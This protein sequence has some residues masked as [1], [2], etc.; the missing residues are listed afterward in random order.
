M[1][2]FKRYKIQPEGRN[3]YGH[4]YSTENVKS[5]LTY[6]MYGGNVSTEEIPTGN[7]DT[8]TPQQPTTYIL[9]FLSTQGVFSSA[10]IA[11]SQKTMDTRLVSYANNTPIPSYIGNFADS[12]DTHYGITGYASSGMSFNILNSGTSATTLQIIVDSGI[13]VSSGTLSIPCYVPK[14]GEEG[15][16]SWGDWKVL[17]D[18]GCL[19]YQELQYDWNMAGEGASVFYLDLTNETGGVNCDEEGHILPGAVL[20]DSWARLYYGEELLSGATYSIYVAP[21]YEANGVNFNTNTGY[22][23]FS[24][25]LSFNGTTLVIEV[26]GTYLGTSRTKKFTLTKNIP[27]Q[28]GQ[29]GSP[30][31]TKWIETSVDEIAFDPNTSAFTPSNVSATVM[32]QVGSGTPYE[33]TSA[34]T[35]YYRF[36]GDAGWNSGTS[37]TVN[38]GF[39]LKDYIEFGLVTPDFTMYEHETVHILKNG[40]NGESVSGSTGPA[41]PAVRGPVDWYSGITVNRRFCNGRGPNAG[42]DKFIDILLKDGTY[43]Q[44]NI[45]YDATPSDSWDSVSGNWTASDAAYDFVATELLLAENAKIKFLSNNALYLMSGDTVTGGAQG[46]SGNTVAFWAGSASGNTAPFSVNHDGHLTARNADIKGNI[47]A[48]TGYF[49]GSITANTGTFA[50][51]VRVPYY[52]IS[53]LGTEI[54]TYGT[55]YYAGEHAYLSLNLSS[56][57]INSKTFTVRKYR[58]G[59]YTTETQLGPGL[60]LPT[61]NSSLN[62]FTYRILVSPYLLSTRF[63]TVGSAD[64]VLLIGVLGSNA[65]ERISIYDYSHS[66]LAPSKINIIGFYGGYIEITC[67]LDEWNNYRWV[68]TTCTGPVSYFTEMYDTSSV[69]RYECYNGSVSGFYAFAQKDY[70][71]MVMFMQVDPVEQSSV[72]NDTMFILKTW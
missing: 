50:G 53:D 18:T 8:N 45:S 37:V 67:M 52:R 28:D 60:Y 14:N 70:N 63:P 61:P 35:V 9:F 41:G 48:D 36:S 44:C 42:D 16:I 54:G 27:G 51:Y 11:E 64:P 12:A 46:G 22:L 69:L 72:N 1:T 10:E 24:N 33:I 68:V 20:P 2:T 5:N 4:Y 17:Y 59:S 13:S 65:N 3:K 55:G 66:D 56:S 57:I 7:N 31:V 71:D 62:G 25:N 39:P 40:L 21:A 43:Y 23:Y 32:I 47:S 15:M 34:E 6:A 38:V 26:T 49:N 29:P 58:G 30:A 19:F